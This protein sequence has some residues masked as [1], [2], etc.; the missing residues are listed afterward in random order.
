MDAAT[1]QRQG[2]AITGVVGSLV[3]CLL[4]LACPGRLVAQ[5][6]APHQPSAPVDTGWLSTDAASVMHSF[7]GY[8]LLPEESRD[9]G[10]WMGSVDTADAGSR[11]VS[12]P[13]S[14]PPYP[15]YWLRPA[16]SSEREQ[17]MAFASL[18]MDAQQS[19]RVEAADLPR[20]EFLERHRLMLSVLIPVT[21]LG[22]VTA[23]A[24]LPY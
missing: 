5:E 20:W 12:A 10:F 13:A 11:R 18:A 21:T 17:H 2:W 19:G 16:D 3:L 24:L 22:A 4:L 15:A 14:A 6:R 23:D 9:H 1:A 7:P 8:R